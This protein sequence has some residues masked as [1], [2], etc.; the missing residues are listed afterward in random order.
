ME[1]TLGMISAVPPGEGRTFQVGNDRIAVFHTR[2]GQVFATQ[3]RCPHRGGPLADG[4]LGGNVLICPLHGR[5]F[6]LRTGEALASADADACGLKT[7]GARVD[8]AGR[9]LVRMD[10]RGSFVESGEGAGRVHG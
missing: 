9:I 1:I 6:D 7:Y 2:G 5:K 3:A 8:S 10:S 4:L